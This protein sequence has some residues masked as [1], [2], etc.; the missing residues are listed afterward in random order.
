VSS[1]DSDDEDNDAK[2][3]RT[4]TNDVKNSTDKNG[5]SD[6]DG[7]EEVFKIAPVNFR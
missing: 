7:D 6:G 4:V 1:D 3:S 5:K 2:K